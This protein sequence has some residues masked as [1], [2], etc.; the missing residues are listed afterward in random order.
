MGDELSWPRRLLLY[1][2]C[3]LI[4]HH[5]RVSASWLCYRCGAVRHYY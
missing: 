3:S 1:F 5:W 4:G 2:W